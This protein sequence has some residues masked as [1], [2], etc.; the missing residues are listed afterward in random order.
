M[1]AFAKKHKTQKNS[2]QVNIGLIKKFKYTYSMCEPVVKM[3]NKQFDNIK[4]IFDKTEIFYIGVKTDFEK[5]LSD[6]KR[7]RAYCFEKALDDYCEKALQ[8]L[9]KFV[10][11]GNE[12]NAESVAIMYILLSSIQKLFEKILHHEM[13]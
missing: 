2:R 8:A 11:E 3:I 6:N 9:M 4:K 12:Y 10:R 5:C 13:I 1:P 7:Y